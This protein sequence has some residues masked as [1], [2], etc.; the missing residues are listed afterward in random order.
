M[1]SRRELAQ[2]LEGTGVF[3]PTLSWYDKLK[4][5]LVFETEN[6][7]VH[8]LIVIHLILMPLVLGVLFGYLALKS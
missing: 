1:L 4:E 6:Q 3:L 5:R 8:S 2:S 7:L